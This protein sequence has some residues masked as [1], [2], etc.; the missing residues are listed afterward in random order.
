V[1]FVT[2]AVAPDLTHE[3]AM[4]D[5]VG[6]EA[7]RRIKMAGPIIGVARRVPT[8]SRCRPGMSVTQPRSRENPSKEEKKKKKEKKKRKKEKRK[9]KAKEKKNKTLKNR[10]N[11]GGIA[12]HTKKGT[13]E[14]TE[15][16]PRAEK[17]AACPGENMG[18]FGNRAKYRLA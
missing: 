6:W 15:E 8:R 1:V 2:V 14:Q 5:D 7:G 18:A 4:V 3:V 16:K 17:D 13:P 10:K 12:G 11:N 9:K